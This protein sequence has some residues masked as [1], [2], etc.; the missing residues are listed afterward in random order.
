MAYQS[1][2]FTNIDNNPASL[3]PGYVIYDARLGWRSNS[4]DWEVILAGTNLTNKFYYQNTFRGPGIQVVTGQP[5]PPREWS[6][7]LRRN[8]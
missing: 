1:S 8:F 7:G 6:L 5:A 2:F 3:T 4:K